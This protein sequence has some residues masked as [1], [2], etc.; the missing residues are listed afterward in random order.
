MRLGGGRGGVHLCLV[1]PVRGKTA[2][3]RPPSELSP[4]LP[5]AAGHGD[6]HE[7]AS[8]LDALVCAALGLLGLLLGLDLGRLALDLTCG[9]VST[10]VRGPEKGA[11]SRTGTSERSVNFSHDEFEVCESACC[12]LVGRGFQSS[13]M[14]MGWRW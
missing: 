12:G 4:Y 1:R 8:V 13:A 7:A 9:G 10:W 11:K 3:G 5:L 14:I 2:S 6:I